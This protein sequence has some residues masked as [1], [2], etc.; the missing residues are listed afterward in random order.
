MRS[1]LWANILS[2]P[3][4]CKI[5]ALTPEL[6]KFF[7]STWWDIKMIYDRIVIIFVNITVVDVIIA[8]IIM[9]ATTIIKLYYV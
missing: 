3:D 4:W 8:I 2:W 6:G 7:H 5:K 9:I 1:N